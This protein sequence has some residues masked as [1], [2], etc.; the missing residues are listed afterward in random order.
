M[1]QVMDQ[2]RSKSSFLDIDKSHGQSLYIEPHTFTTVADKST[3]EIAQK[4]KMME[5]IKTE[6][7]IKPIKTQPQS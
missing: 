6:S 3:K 7:P 5:H 4:P 1:F 2:Q